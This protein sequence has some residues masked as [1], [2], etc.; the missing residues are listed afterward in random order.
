MRRRY[1]RVR[2]IVFVGIPPN[3]K[4]PGEPPP[5]TGDDVVNP[6]PERLL[7]LSSP[8]TI[9]PYPPPSQSSIPLSPPSPHPHHPHGRRPQDLPRGE[10]P[11]G[12]ERAPKLFSVS[13]DEQLKALADRFQNRD[14]PQ[15]FREEGEEDWAGSARF[16]PKG[17]VHSVKPY[18]RFIRDS[19]EKTGDE[20]DDTAEIGFQNSTAEA[21]DNNRMKGND[22]RQRVSNE[23]GEVGFNRKQRGRHNAKRP[24]YRKDRNV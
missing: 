18:G 2:S 22:S 17:V 5:A 24:D 9:P 19:N 16:F 21:E 1:K 15:L 23:N 8:N 12:H 11:S 6:N 20:D 13:A 4:E 3:S 10:S 7:L 14:G